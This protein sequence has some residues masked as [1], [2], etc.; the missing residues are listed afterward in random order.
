MVRDADYY[1]PGEAA[2][3]L[4]VPPIR[5]FTM[6]CS[7]ELEGRQDERARWWVPVGAVERTRQR[8]EA[9]SGPS[10]PSDH[11]DVEGRA[12]N[13]EARS[14]RILPPL[15]GL[16]SGADMAGSEETSHEQHEASVS[17]SSPTSRTNA[18]GAEE[19]DHYT[20]D[21]AA[22]ILELSPACVRQI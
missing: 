6:L 5:I 10:D 9:P 20:V 12:A 16:P 14:E 7:G 11:D 19:D 8:L 22:Q 17:V 1:T 15:Q 2:K 21:E 4:G 3:A 18:A 13:G